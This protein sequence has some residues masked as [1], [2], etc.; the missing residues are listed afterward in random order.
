VDAAFA[1]LLPLI[2]G[3]HYVRLCTYV[4]YSVAREDGH[5]LYFRVAYYGVLLFLVS[6]IL[7]SG[8]YAALQGFSW[9]QEAQRL[10]EAGLGPLFKDQNHAMAQIGFLL[11]CL[12]SIPL[13]RWSPWVINGLF[14]KLS[15]R[16]LWEAAALNELEELLLAL[17]T[18]RSI[19]ITLSSNKVYVGF[20]LS[21]FLP[22]TDRR[23]ISVLPMMSG[24]RTEEG[25]VVFTTFYDKQIDSAPA[26][27][28]NDEFNLVLPIDKML[29]ISF[30]DIAIYARF[31]AGPDIA[32][33]GPGALP[34]DGS[35]EAP[36]VEVAQ[37]AIEP[38]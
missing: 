13:G 32:G 29:S 7:L 17:T 3:Y 23:F 16:A 31:N 15:E 6:L 35:Q 14:K 37:W 24:Y 12:T 9:F 19:S 33:P 1:L 28:K 30:F 20:A 8:L 25:R 21:T 10:I 34:G 38:S 2:G 26:E 27:A 4:R 18:A 11:I 22:P 5:R 36:P